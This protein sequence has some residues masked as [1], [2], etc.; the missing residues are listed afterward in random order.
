MIR[1]KV[2]GTDGD[3]TGGYALASYRLLRWLQPVVKWERLHVR[4]VV[5]ERRRKAMAGLNILSDPE[6]LRLQ[7][8]WVDVS[9]SA[10]E[11]DD[12][13]FVQLISIF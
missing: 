4:G 5:P 11:R 8:N 6:W 9:S 2:Q 10:P 1:R 3:D 13:F 7:V 12:E